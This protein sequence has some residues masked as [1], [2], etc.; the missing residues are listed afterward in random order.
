MYKFKKIHIQEKIF[1]LKK[2][3]LIIK[4]FIN[5]KNIKIKMIKKQKYK[6]IKKKNY[7]NS[8]TIDQFVMPKNISTISNLNT[9][10]SNKTIIHV[11]D[12]KYPVG[13]GDFLRGS[14]LLAQ[15]AKY[16]N[17]NFK[18]NI[19]GHIISN[20]L[21]NISEILPPDIKINFLGWSDYIKLELF[22]SK[23]NEF[24]KSNDMVF[25]IQTNLF[26]NKNLVSNDICEYI[27][28]C[29]TFK[30]K[31][32]D[33]ANKLNSLKDY[34]ILHIRCNDKNFNTN[35]NDDELFKKI[36]NLKLNNNTITLSN[37]Y[38]LKKKINKIFG[39]YYIDNKAVH[40]A[41]TNNYTDLEATIIDYIILTRSSKTY[42]FSYYGHGSGFS[43]HSSKLNN[44]PYECFIMVK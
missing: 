30:Q 32:Y 26:Y 16:Y 12:S 28:S 39:F 19:S 42:C 18:I 7:I 40:I 29:F 9:S 27:N 13:L 33:I 24:I 2:A 14:I 41:K 44:I 23:I 43:E 15:Y 5:K 34:N 20:Y 4:S 10:D 17:M 22:E 8:K 11:Y 35:F 3:N 31:Y 25:Y 37:N 21:N 6:N 38:Q 36:R 1:K